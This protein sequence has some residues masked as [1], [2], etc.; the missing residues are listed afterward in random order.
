[1]SR[2]KRPRGG[3]RIPRGWRRAAAGAVAAGVALT[4]A[5]TGAA[6]AAAPAACT[7]IGGGKYNCNFYVAGNGK[8]GGT[9]VQVGATTVGY[10]HKGTNW[11]LCQQV[12]GRVTAGGFFNSNW[13]WTLADNNKYGWV[14]AV[15]ASG[16]DNDGAFGGGVPSCN[17]AHG[18]P[19]GGPGPGPPAPGPAPGPAPPTPGF[20]KDVTSA[21][22]KAHYDDAASWS[23]GKNCTG[24]FTVGAKRLQAWIRANW[25]AAT[26]QGYNCRPNTADR[27]KTSIHGVGRASDW[28]RKAG[29]AAQAAQVASFIQRMSANGAAMARAMGVQYWIW[30]RQQYSVKGNSVA[31]SRYTGPN[32]HTD[33]VHIEQNLAGSKLQTSYWRLAGR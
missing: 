6:M 10:L 1:M 17:N 25:G 2:V 30:N 26:I 16:G 21:P 32:P 11:V 33:H 4:A 24:G 5:G 20:P 12:G 14:N 28:F 29:N 18:A 13:A 8:S 27:S 31:R 3:A 19:P 15:Y 9:P 23:G 7:A 22:D